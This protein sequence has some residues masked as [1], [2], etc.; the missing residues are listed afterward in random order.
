MC[1]KNGVKNDK[2]NTNILLK[3]LHREVKGMN[4]WHYKMMMKIIK[5]N[6]INIK[7]K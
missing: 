1:I 2:K 7:K 6:W 3:Y 4:T 5:K